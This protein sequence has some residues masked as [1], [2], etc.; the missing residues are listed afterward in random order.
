MFKLIPDW[1]QG[2]K[3]ADFGIRI[4]RNPNSIYRSLQMP[5]RPGQIVG[6]RPNRWENAALQQGPRKIA[7]VNLPGMI[8]G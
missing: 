3:A 5:T 1:P 6:V 2:R 7:L 8:T 4:C